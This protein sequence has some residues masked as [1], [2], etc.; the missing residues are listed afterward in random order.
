MK[1]EGGVV[2]EW[3]RDDIGLKVEDLHVLKCEEEEEEEEGSGVTGEKN[4]FTRAICF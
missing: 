2:L 4:L 3:W 1:G